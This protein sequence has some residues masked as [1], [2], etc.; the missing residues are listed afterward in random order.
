MPANML[1]VK[2]VH[3]DKNMFQK[4]NSKSSVNGNIMYEP[5]PFMESDTFLGGPKY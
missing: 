1:K 2:L 5:E 3:Y 4:K